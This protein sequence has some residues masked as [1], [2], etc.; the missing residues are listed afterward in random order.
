L[1]W[2][3]GRSRSRRRRVQILFEAL[4]AVLID[5]LSYL[6]AGIALSAEDI[7]IAHISDQFLAAAE[8]GRGQAENVRFPVVT[9]MQQGGGSILPVSGWEDVV[10]VVQ[11]WSRKGVYEAS[12]LY[13]WVSQSLNMRR[14]EITAKMLSLA[15]GGQGVL[16]DRPRGGICYTFYRQWKSWPLYDDV[17]RVWYV[18][19]RYYGRAVDFADLQSAFAG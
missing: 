4:R 2:R 10:A 15:Q 3:P 19:A 7:R 13:D 12:G 8:P 1:A 14:E 17:A 11:T 18:T 16:L 9:L 5:R 6:P